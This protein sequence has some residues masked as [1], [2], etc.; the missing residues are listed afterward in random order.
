MKRKPFFKPGSLKFKNSGHT[1]TFSGRHYR[2]TLDC[3]GKCD[4]K[5]IQ[6]D[7]RTLE[8]RFS[9]LGSKFKIDDKSFGKLY[10]RMLAEYLPILI[11]KA[12]EKAEEKDELLE[13]TIKAIE[14]DVQTKNKI[15]SSDEKDFKESIN[16]QNNSINIM[17]LFAYLVGIVSVFSKEKSEAE[18]GKSLALI[19]KYIHLSDKGEIESIE[20][21]KW[22]WYILNFIDKQYPNYLS[23]LKKEGAVIINKKED[24][25]DYDPLKAIEYF[26]SQNIKIAMSDYRVNYFYNL[27]EKIQK[28]TELTM[29][30]NTENI[31]KA[32]FELFNQLSINPSMK[33]V[34]A[35]SVIYK[36]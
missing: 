2:C 25:C 22:G 11:L 32:I 36:K 29:E 4:K 8:R 15:K 7:S 30:A 9:Y 12:E 10:R 34:T 6:I 19:T 24:Y 20:L 5:E 14:K 26:D 33:F 21:E 3:N 35:L 17:I 16:E 1:L 28:L 31:P 13:T 23:N 18:L 27:I